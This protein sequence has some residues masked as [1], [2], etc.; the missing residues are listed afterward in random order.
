MD[1][2]YRKNGSYNDILRNVE[3]VKT[4]FEIGTQNGGSA[5]ILSK[6]FPHAKVYTM[7]IN[8][9]NTNLGENIISITSDVTNLII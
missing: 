5:Q 4:I 3:N 8:P 6:L 1:Q 2:L 9:L 7:D